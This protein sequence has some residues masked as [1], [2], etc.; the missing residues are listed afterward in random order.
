MTAKLLRRDLSPYSVSLS[1]GQVSTN[2]SLRSQLF[3]FGYCDHL[4]TF[5][6]LSLLEATLRTAQS[7][8]SLHV[9][10]NRMHI[11]QCLEI[12]DLC[13]QGNFQQAHLHHSNMEVMG[14][15]QCTLEGGSNSMGI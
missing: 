6:K 14:Y 12:S 11:V 2:F 4:T 3:L 9:A 10:N 7:R 13:M 15:E 8:A 1:R 5:N